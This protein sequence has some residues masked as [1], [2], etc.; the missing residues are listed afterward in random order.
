MSRIP[1]E[2]ITRIKEQ[3]P[4]EELCRQRGINLEKHG[5]KDLK[6]LCPFHDDKE[7]SFIVSP[8]KNLFNCFGCGASG[9][10]LDFV[11]KI[12]GVSFR[13]A[14]EILQTNPAATGG[15]TNARKCT[16]KKLASPLSF[17][18]D[19]R[20]LMKQTVEY[21]TSTLEKSQAALEYLGNRGLKSPDLV[22][23]FRIGYSN[24]T[25]G[26]HLP[27][28][29]RKAGDEIRGRLTRLGIYRESGHEHFSG[30]IVFPVWDAGGHVV[31]MYGRRIAKGDGTK[32]LY[33]PGPHAG[34]WNA[35]GVGDARE[36]LLCES[37]IDALSFWVHGF[38]NV[39]A[40]YGA[41][42]FTPEYL[43]LVRSRRPERVIVAYDNDD[44][45]NVAA[46]EL[47]Q[48]LEPEGVAVW[49]AELPPG[50]DVNELIVHSENP[51]GALSSLLA[52]AVRMLPEN[53][54]AI[55]FPAVKTPEVPAKSAE[56]TEEES[57]HDGGKEKD[58]FEAGDD[59]I[60]FRRGE[61]A[62]RARGLDRNTSF[63]HL[64]V[65]LRLQFRGKFH[66]DSF[67]LYN[68]RQRAAFTAAAHQ[69]TGIEHKII[70]ED[71]SILIP[72]TESE[73]EKRILSK[74]SVDVKA[75]SMTPEDEQRALALLRDP[76]ICGRVLADF[77]TAGTVGE[78]SNKLVGYLV[79]VSRKLDDPLSAVIMSRS[80]AGKSSLLNA[81]L[82]FVPEEDKEMLTSMTAQAL[83][84]MPTDGLRHKV[85]AL[86][87]DEGS[88]RACYPLKI[89]QSEKVLV[90]AVTVKDPESGIMQTKQRKVDGPV[91]Q[92]MT[93]TQAELDYELANR[94]LVLTVDEERGQ[95]R[96]IHEAQRE[97]ETLQGLLKKME[98]EDILKIHHNAQRLLRPLPVV[99][100]FAG[101]LTFPDDRL[102]LRRDHKKYLGLI[103][104][105]AFIRQ[106]QK[107]IRSCEHRGKT[108]Q[109]I[110]VDENDLRISHGLAVS[111]LGRCLDELAPPARAFLAGLHGSVR[112]IAAERN[113]KIPSVRMTQRSIREATGWSD[114]QVRRH[115]ERLIE[116]EY[117]IRHRV[118]GTG[119][120]FEYELVYDGQGQSGE[121]FLPFLSGADSLMQGE[122]AP[123]K[124]DPPPEN[125][126]PPCDRHASATGSPQDRHDVDARASS[127]LVLS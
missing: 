78:E 22:R 35:D 53:R 24:R 5:A 69:V 71:L 21:Y 114:T 105:V 38:E 10:N 120:R 52:A 26:Y 86:A 110:E 73:Q 68:A 33:L 116:M 37:I 88:E 50:G 74:M 40:S 100:P 93:S 47:S 91:A 28:K 29:N 46:N 62:Y 3:I 20:E 16:V 87:E 117:V 82:E 123:M 89:L 107:Q 94:Y 32:H 41:R 4:L 83:F 84:Y 85:L 90:L 99:N 49:R 11:M 39:T 19:D 34:V 101:K 14:A 42:G 80:A 81:V 17:D 76:D 104:T 36:W 70:E 55:P 103:R 126:V 18:A 8:D 108:I 127:L 95:T 115:L 56:K 27:M 12:E 9:S 48:R 65:N 111:V 125:H 63:D 30:C 67:D 92:L 54:R 31:E 64:K 98:K 96:R 118:P 79:A 43:E 72:L 2:E 1:E 58:S 7:A 121:K 122:N 45:G 66:I 25:L 112:K 57:S 75:P 102:R 61:R 124:H 6:G 106:F 23:R 119:A 13:H 51:R 59:R 97:A 77:E 15:V 60:M 109:Y 44:A 113:V